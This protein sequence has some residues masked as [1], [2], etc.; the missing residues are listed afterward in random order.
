MRINP[1]ISGPGVSTL[2]KKN[3]GHITQ[4]IGP[5]VVFLLA[6]CLIFTMLW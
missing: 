4:I 1:T 3:L 2:E 6:R 5:D